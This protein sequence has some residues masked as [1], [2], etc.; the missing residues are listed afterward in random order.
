MYDKVYCVNKNTAIA[1]NNNRLALTLNGKDWEIVIGDSVINTQ[2]I[3]VEVHSDYFRFEDI[4]QIND[5]SYIIFGTKRSI[6][7]TNLFKTW[8]YYDHVAENISVLDNGELLSN[9]NDNIYFAEDNDS[10]WL[11][12]LDISKLY[13]EDFDYNIQDFEGINSNNIIYTDSYDTYLTNDGGST[14]TTLIPRAGRF[15]K[16]QKVNNSFVF[17]IGTSNHMGVGSTINLVKIK[18]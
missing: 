13:D 16:L 7:T 4:F 14:W 12:L 10:E 1:F 11:Q 17:G 3:K 18:F 8:N 15:N 9:H 6:I 2:G 5:S